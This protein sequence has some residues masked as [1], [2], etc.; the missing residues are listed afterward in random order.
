MEASAA[1]RRRLFSTG[2]PI[3][4][5]VHQ[6]GWLSPCRHWSRVQ[7]PAEATASCQ[8]LAAASKADSASASA[9][10]EDPCAQEATD[11]VVWPGELPWT[12]TAPGP[13]PGATTTTPTAAAALVPSSS[14]VTGDLP[15]E[16]R[17]R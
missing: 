10:G 11:P 5:R 8:V 16:G 1:G 9:C 12:P 4:V 13:A 6:Q 15:G 2:L 7:D 3:V 17:D 14:V